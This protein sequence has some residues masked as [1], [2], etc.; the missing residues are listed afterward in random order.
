M[1]ACQTGG[2]VSGIWRDAGTGGGTISGLS[3]VLKANNP[4]VET[5]A[6]EP[7]ESPVLSR[8]QVGPHKIQGIGAGVVPGNYDSSVVD[9]AVRVSGDDAVA[10]A[11]M[12][13]R[14]ERVTAEISSGAALSAAIRLA[15]MPEYERNLTYVYSTVLFTTFQRMFYIICS[16]VSCQ[17]EQHKEQYKNVHIVLKENFH[18]FACFHNFLGNPVLGDGKFF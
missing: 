14:Y 6:V 12:L 8:G 16:F 5:V 7:A 2:I 1:P 17:A 18:Y 15:S 9:K 10:T 13:M 4:A 11:W 3:K